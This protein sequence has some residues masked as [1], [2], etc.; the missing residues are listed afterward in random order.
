[1]GTIGFFLVT[2]SGLA[3]TIVYISIIHASLKD[4]TYGMP[5]AALSLNFAW[6]LLYT[7]TGFL[8]NPY[9]IQTWV[10]FIWCFFD[11]TIIYCYFKFGKKEFERVADKK[12][13]IPWSLLIFSMALILQYGFYIEFDTN[14]PN[15]LPDLKDFI[16]PR[17]SAWYSAFLQNLLM[18]V[19]FINMLVTRKNSKG[20]TMVVAVSKFIGTLAP[21]ILF[22]VILNNKLV[23]IAGFFCTVFDVIYI[24][25]LSKYKKQSI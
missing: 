23:L 17:L 12:Y 20:Q 14:S 5:I 10:N 4:K 13:F 9:N 3:W 22:G 2:A 16:D 7:V 18:S 24:W 25:L 1:M 21:T 15:Y 11:L 6:E 8:Y 19:L